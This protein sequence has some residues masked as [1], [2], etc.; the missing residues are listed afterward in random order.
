MSYPIIKYRNVI[1]VVK[2]NFFK[3]DEYK[4]FHC[5]QNFYKMV[6]S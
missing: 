1:F 6:E 3:Y 5:K 4:F 2:L